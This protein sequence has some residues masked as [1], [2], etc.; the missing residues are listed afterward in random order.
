MN[1]SKETFSSASHGDTRGMRFLYATTIALIISNVVTIVV[2]F[3][4]ASALKNNINI[5]ASS[6]TPAAQAYDLDE[7]RCVAARE[8]CI[9]GCIETFP[10]G[11]AAVN[12]LSCVADCEAV[13]VCTR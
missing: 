13:N 6:Q 11:A 1:N 5:V 2:A 8:S 7:G 3:T 10:A 12:Y 9:D 4:F